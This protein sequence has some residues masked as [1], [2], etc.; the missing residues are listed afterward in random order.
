MVFIFP[1]LHIILPKHIRKPEYDI[2]QDKEGKETYCLPFSM[3]V[4]HKFCRCF[5][6]P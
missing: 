2:I 1:A 6:Y 3:L 5:F 4:K